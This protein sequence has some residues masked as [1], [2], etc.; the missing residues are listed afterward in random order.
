MRCRTVYLLVEPRAVEGRKEGVRLPP[1]PAVAVF[2]P[3][4]PAV[5][6]AADS[7]LGRGLKLSKAQ[8]CP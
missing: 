8:G 4:Q 1:A 2:P 5:Q 7:L 6:A 3:Q